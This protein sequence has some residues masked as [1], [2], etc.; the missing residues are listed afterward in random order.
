LTLGRLAGSVQQI[1]QFQFVD[2][3]APGSVSW[4]SP[5][6]FEGVEVLVA[7]IPVHLLRNGGGST[8]LRYLDIQIVKI[9]HVGG[10][11]NPGCR[12]IWWAAIF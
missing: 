1:V 4:S 11:L 10:G 5:E 7:Q 8:V 3:I 6:C 12:S 9:A 2:L